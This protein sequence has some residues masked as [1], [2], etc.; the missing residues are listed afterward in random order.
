MDWR[1][2]VNP[3]NTING[4]EHQGTRR[5]WEAAAELSRRIERTVAFMEEH[6]DQP[7]TA[8][9]LASLAFL[10]VSHYF[11]LFKQLTGRSPIN[12][13][14]DLRMQRGRRLLVDTSMSVK[15][16]AAALG[17]DDPFYFSRVFK[18]VN[19]IAPTDYRAI[20]QGLARRTRENSFARAFAGSARSNQRPVGA[21]GRKDG[22]SEF[23]I[24]ATPAVC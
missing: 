9:H 15:E 17:Y 18:S 7:L 24:V 3:V 21:N 22:Q 23:E 11:A 16:V 14:T 5:N 4:P 10:S 8:A 6:L 12:Y 2:K 1:R 20:Q 13:L 19:G